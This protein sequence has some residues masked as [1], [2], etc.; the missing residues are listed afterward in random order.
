MFKN[1]ITGAPMAVSNKSQMTIVAALVF[2]WRAGII[3]DEEYNMTY[4]E[5]CEV[6]FLPQS[7][8]GG[9]V[10]EHDLSRWKSRK[11]WA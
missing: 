6:G 5:V 11:S 8:G 9:P 10:D 2:A 4:A 1:D 3:T 7:A